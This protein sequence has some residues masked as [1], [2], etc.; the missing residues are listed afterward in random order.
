MRPT[1][2]RALGLGTDQKLIV[3]SSTWGPDS[4][5]ATNPDLPLAL[6]TALP[7]DE[8]RITLAMHPNIAAYHSRWQV[9]EYLADAARAGV[10]VPDSV[11][12]WRVAI[13]AADL[14]VSDHGSVG[15]YSTALGNPILLATAPAHTVDPAS[16]IA[17]LLNSAPRLDDSGDIAAQVRRAIDEHDTGRYAAIGAL[18]TSIPGS[19]AALL[20][21]AMYRAMDLPEPARPPALTTLPVPQKPL[22][23]PNAHMVVVHMDSERTATVTRYPAERL[24]TAHTNGRRSHLAVGVDEPQIRWLESADVLIGGHGGEAAAWITETL[25]HLRNCAIACAPA[26]HGRWLVG[27]ATGLLSVRGADLGCRLFASLSREL[28]ADG[29]AF[30]DLLGEWRISCAA[31]T[32]PVTV[33]AAAEL[34]RPSSR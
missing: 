7:S 25:A 24:S 16:P 34:D 17:R 18:T 12:D 31:T 6:A 9:A 10:H 21:T 33:E 19:A 30:D 29:A 8:F 28:R 14:T 4:L 32:Y 1:Y 27:D 20:R 15:F 22:H 13:I 2:R 23:A 3:L 26:E 5:L 11:D